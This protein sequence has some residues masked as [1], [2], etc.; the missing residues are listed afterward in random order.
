MKERRLLGQSAGVIGR[1]EVTPR[2]DQRARKSRAGGTLNSRLPLQR[3]QARARA[4]ATA[5]WALPSRKDEVHAQPWGGGRAPTSAEQPRG[6]GEGG[7]ANFDAWPAST[8]P[9]GIPSV[10]GHPF[11]SHALAKTLYPQ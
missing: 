9:R 4:V 11:L 6:S 2:D 7:R 10:M 8:P 3:L 5:D 1:R